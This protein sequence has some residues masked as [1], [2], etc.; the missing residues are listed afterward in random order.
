[1]RNL[2]Y[3]IPHNVQSVDI[4]CHIMRNL[5][6][7]LPHSAQSGEFYT[8]QCAIWSNLYQQMRNLG[9]SITDDAQ[10]GIFA[11]LIYT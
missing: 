4:L 11:S 5:D 2:D 8:T 9:Y 1:M 7:N 6:Y 3:N 10:Y